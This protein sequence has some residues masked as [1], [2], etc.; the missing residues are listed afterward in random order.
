M[1]QENVKVIYE[2]KVIPVDKIFE[3]PNNDKIFSMKDIEVL[4]KSILEK[5]FIGAIDV[6]DLGNGTYEVFS[7]HRRLRAVKL[8]GMSEIRCRVYPNMSEKEKIERLIDLNIY[9]R[10]LS[11]MDFAR[12]IDFYARVVLGLEK[13]K[14]ESDKSWVDHC[15]EHFNKSRS[16]IY[17]YTRLLSLI[18]QLQELADQSDIPFTKLTEAVDLDENGQMELYEAINSKRKSNSESV[19]TGPVVSN[20]IYNIKQKQKKRM[21][22]MITQEEKEN[23]LL[24]PRINILDYCKVANLSK[25]EEKELYEMCSDLVKS[26]SS[27]PLDHD[28]IINIIN[29]IKRNHHKA[30]LDRSIFDFDSNEK[31][32]DSITTDSEILNDC[33]SDG[34][35]TNE[36]GIIDANNDIANG[37]SIMINDRTVPDNSIQEADIIET[38]N[39]AVSA[40]VTAKEDDP[41]KDD[42][43]ASVITNN[44]SIREKLFTHGILTED[45]ILIDPIVTTLNSQLNH[46]ANRAYMINNKE[47]L[48]AELLNMEQIIRSILDQIK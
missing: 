9:N 38:N 18:P 24:S 35:G 7:G 37:N 15:A 12:A 22:D 33:S 19:I 34:E 28:S 1:S 4:A 17:T 48:E 14:F 27:S 43:K 47:N 25:K 40:E 16:M 29:Q 39:D 6:F 11:P 30:I 46:I 45:K 26:G 23:K 10:D 3:N 31:S 36:S 8:N 5:G 13:K 20:M 21:L 44:E 41:D 42:N 2:E 32:S